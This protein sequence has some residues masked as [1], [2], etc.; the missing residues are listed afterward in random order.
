MVIFLLSQVSIQLLRWFSIQFFFHVTPSLLSSTVP[1]SDSS[2]NWQITYPQSSSLTTTA[3]FYDTTSTYCLRQLILLC[4]LQVVCTS[5]TQPLWQQILVT[6]IEFHSSNGISCWCSADVVHPT[7]F[8][9]QVQVSVE[10]EA[11]FDNDDNVDTT[12]LSRRLRTQS[13]SRFYLFFQEKA[14][15]LFTVKA[16]LYWFI[17]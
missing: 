14:T 15:L 5:Y 6:Y 9:I 12:A 11:L 13:L 3:S 16:F 7:C 1:N 10:I 17:Q 2:V 4:P 8:S